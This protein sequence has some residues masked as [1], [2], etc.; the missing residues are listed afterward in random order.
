MGVFWECNVSR[1]FASDPSIEIY[2]FGSFIS[3]LK[4]AIYKMVVK[5]GS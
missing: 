3:V 1:Q 4:N 5:V 2:A